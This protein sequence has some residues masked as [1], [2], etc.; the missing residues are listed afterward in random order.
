MKITR[1]SKLRDHVAF[2]RPVSVYRGQLGTAAPHL[3]YANLDFGEPNVAT[4]GKS[5]LSMP[6]W[7]DTETLQ[8]LA[9]HQQEF[10]RCLE[11]LIKGAR[12]S[13]EID[14]DGTDE[15][16]DV[17]MRELW[18]QQPEIQFLQQHGLAHAQILLQPGSQDGSFFCGL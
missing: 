7:T 13:F 11:W 18:D 12:T 9:E 17:R 4:K 8:F 10:R 3:L 14:D 1:V 5:L 16:F 6:G 15:V 2:L